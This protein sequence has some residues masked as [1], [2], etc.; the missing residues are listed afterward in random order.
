MKM[1]KKIER[2]NN[3]E[4]NQTDKVKLNNA[5]MTEPFFYKKLFILIIKLGI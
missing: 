4:Y 3:K 5:L 1:M 2:K